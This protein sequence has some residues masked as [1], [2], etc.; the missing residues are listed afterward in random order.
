MPIGSIL[1]Q[2]SDPPRW[3]FQL[4]L[5]SSE[6][7]LQ[8][9]TRRCCCFSFPQIINDCIGR[10]TRYAV[11]PSSGDLWIFE[12]LGEERAEVWNRGRDATGSPQI[13]PTCS[14]SV[15]STLRPFSRDPQ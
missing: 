3:V 5:A 9:T 2:R 8:L 12:E 4:A 14:P 13:Y 15:A 11:S 1:L 6:V 7:Q 10:S